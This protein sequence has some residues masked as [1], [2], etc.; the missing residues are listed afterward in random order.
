MADCYWHIELDKSSFLLWTFNPPFGR[1]KFKKLPFQIYC[2]SDIYCTSQLMTERH[3]ADIKGVIA[4]HDNLII[5]SVLLSKHDKTLIF[6]KELRTR[7]LSSTSRK[8]KCNIWNYPAW[9]WTR[10]I[11]DLRNG[12]LPGT[13]HSTPILNFL[14]I[15]QSP[16]ERH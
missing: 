11:V 2:A 9:K 3:F 13:I 5:S 14:S 15:K 8:D 16:K 1:H 10:Y 6:Q 4:V 12:N 7:I